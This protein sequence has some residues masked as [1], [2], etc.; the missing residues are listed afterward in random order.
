MNMKKSFLN[1]L[2]NLVHRRFTFEE[3]K[4]EINSYLS[5]CYPTYTFELYNRDIQDMDSYSDYE[6][7]G[8]VLDKKENIICDFAIYYIKT[9]DELVYI[10]EIAL[11]WYG[12]E[13]D[14][15]EISN[16]LIDIVYDRINDY[17]FYNY[18]NDD[19]LANIEIQEDTNVLDENVINIKIGKFIYQITC[20]GIFRED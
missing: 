19:R 13:T 1:F 20:N 15:A 2:E 4:R 16:K 6:F 14:L 8:S 7:E 12:I 11:D 18:D 9:R 5:S 3:L 10:T 17:N